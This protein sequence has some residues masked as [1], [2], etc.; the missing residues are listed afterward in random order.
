MGLYRPNLTSQ[1]IGPVDRVDLANRRARTGRPRSRSGGAGS[2]GRF[3]SEFGP[4]LAGVDEVGRGPLAGPVVACA[5]IMPPDARAI[6]GVDDSKQLTRAGARA[7]GGPDPLPRA[8]DRSR[9]R[10]G[11]RD[12]PDQHLPCNG[13]GHAPRAGAARA[14]AAPRG[15]R[16]QSRADARRRRTGRSSGAMGGATPW[17]APRSSPKSPATG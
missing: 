5:V 3:V 9:R 13:A 1:P 14:L 10:V 16:W 2:S 15:R 11:A 17:R 12:R 7:A 8:R 4:L 6:R